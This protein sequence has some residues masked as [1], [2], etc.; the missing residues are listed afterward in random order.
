MPYG[1]RSRPFAEA[2]WPSSEAWGKPAKVCGLVARAGRWLAEL[3]RDG[4]LEV[5]YDAKG[6][7]Y[8][9]TKHGRSALNQPVPT[10]GVEPANPER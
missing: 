1:A 3:A 4:Y 6:A 7:R 9:L 5:L 8:R 10:A 2:M